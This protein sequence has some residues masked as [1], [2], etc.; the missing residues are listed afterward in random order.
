MYFFEAYRVLGT[1]FVIPIFY[2]NNIKGGQYCVISLKVFKKTRYNMQSNNTYK[3]KYYNENF[4]YSKGQDY[5][6]PEYSN[7]TYRG[8][9]RVTTSSNRIY[10]CTISEVK[11]A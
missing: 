9:G 10:V 8:G 1:I 7:L 3:D 4:Q 5:Y 2:Q 6:P 11:T